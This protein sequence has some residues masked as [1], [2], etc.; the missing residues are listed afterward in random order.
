M[1]L[2][3]QKGT[4]RMTAVKPIKVYKL[5]FHN[6]NGE[7]G[8]Q[9]ICYDFMWEPNTTV[10]S[11]LKVAASSVYEGLHAFMSLNAAARSGYSFH[12]IVKMTIPKGAH[13]Y[14]GNDNDIVSDT[15]ETGTMKD[16]RCSRAFSYYSG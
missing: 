16:E 5:L 12:C 6:P 9:S 14:I 7:P 3:I 8:F 13:Y 2:T 4:C 1:C 11:K 10:T 15:L